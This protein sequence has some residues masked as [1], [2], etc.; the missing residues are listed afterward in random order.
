MEE[1]DDRREPCMED[2]L[3][4]SV[5]TLN[6]RRVGIEEN[7]LH[8]DDAGQLSDAEST[9]FEPHIELE[10]NISESL[11]GGRKSQKSGTENLQM[12]Y[13]QRRIHKVKS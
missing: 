3:A 11:E 10:L 2:V 13:L 1:R 12:S 9:G 7:I 8:R 5:R 4:C 6:A